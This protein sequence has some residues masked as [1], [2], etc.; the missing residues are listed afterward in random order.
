MKTTL[1]LET[2]RTVLPPGTQDHATDAVL[3]L[4]PRVI[5]PIV[6][7]RT[8]VSPRMMSSNTFV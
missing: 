4:R 6:D 8:N 5:F 7:R 3:L 1:V 2:R